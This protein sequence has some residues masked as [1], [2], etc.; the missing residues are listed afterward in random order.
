MKR[1]ETLSNLLAWKAHFKYYEFLTGYANTCVTDQLAKAR[2]I[3]NLYLETTNNNLFDD[4][5]EL[6]TDSCSCTI[7]MSM[8]LPCKQIAECFLPFHT[9]VPCT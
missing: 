1:Q 6:C 8:G 4:G 2:K 9:C 5:V 7:R 3:N